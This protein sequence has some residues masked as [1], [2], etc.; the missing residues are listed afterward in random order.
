MT[1]D[2]VYTI[3]NHSNEISYID[4]ITQEDEIDIAF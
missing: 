2:S 3:I 4:K 1:K